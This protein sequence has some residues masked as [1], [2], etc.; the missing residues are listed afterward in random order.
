MKSLAKYFPMVV[1]PL[2]L[3]RLHVFANFMLM[4]TE[5]HGSEILVKEYGNAPKN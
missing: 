2:L 3:N 1:F 4:W 5:K